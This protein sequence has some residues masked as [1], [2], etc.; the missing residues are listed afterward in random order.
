MTCDVVIIGGGLIGL[1]SAWQLAEAGVQV[2]VIDP[3]P[4]RGASNVAAGMLAPVTEVTYG[5]QD[6]LTLNI[7]AARRW[8]SFATELSE[9]TGIDVGY[10]PTGTLLVGF[11]DDD[12]AMIADLHAFQTELGLQVQH[13][14]RREAREREPMLSP[15]VR[16]GLL[17]GEDHR[18]DPRA[19]VAALLQAATDAGVHLDRRRVARIVVDGERVTGVATSDGEVVTGDQVVLAAGA[20]SATIDG[21][22]DTA[23]PA[24]RPVKGQL[25]HLR[26]PAG[27]PVLATTVR[28]LVR[29]RSVYLVPRDDGGLVVGASE[30]ERGFDTAVTAG[31]IR[32]LLDDA[33]RIVPGVDELELLETIA[34]VR[35]TTPDNA[36]VI[37]RGELDGLVLATGHH[38]NGVLLTP[39]TADAVTALVTG[40][41]PDPVVTAAGPDRPALRAGRRQT[42]PHTGLDRL[43][44]ANRWQGGA[45]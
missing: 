6:R 37:G 43:V 44:V 11:D 16:V 25:L 14:H 9:A 8:P 20:W 17:A 40:G 18:V 27:D 36:P 13:L 22:P 32:E 31:A 12:A 19:V 24:V 39:V 45:R 38:R 5:E 23:R 7:A 4:G 2:T 42:R 35:P 28:G 29:R 30:E 41:T 34:G 10:R 26:D 3:E 33:A 21:L 15:R 1:A